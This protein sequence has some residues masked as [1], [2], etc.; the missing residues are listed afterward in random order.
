MNVNILI[1][2]KNN[3]QK[4]KTAINITKCLYEFIQ[5]QMIEDEETNITD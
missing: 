5:N 4:E 3:L 2:I 1:A